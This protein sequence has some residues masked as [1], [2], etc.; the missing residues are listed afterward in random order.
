MFK[1]L[2]PVDSTRAFRFEGEMVGEALGSGG[3]RE[4]GRVEDSGHWS[5][6]RLYNTSDGK[7]VCEQVNSNHWTGGDES[8]KAVMC[9]TQREVLEF[10]GK[11]YL[12]Q[13]LYMDADFFCMEQAGVMPSD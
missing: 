2:V 11:S 12:A 4:S 7:Y 8:H 1:M 5:E 10:F 13:E 9:E 3:R 6:L